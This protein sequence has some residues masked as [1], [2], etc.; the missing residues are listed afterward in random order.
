MP[1]PVLTDMKPRLE[2]AARAVHDAEDNLKDAR[3]L[4]NELIVA[5]VDHGMS[6]RAVAKITGLTISR[7]N[8]VWGF[9]PEQS[10]EP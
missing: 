9:G 7:V 10:D 6:Q 1:T 4:R 8:A 3:T 5:A 2:A